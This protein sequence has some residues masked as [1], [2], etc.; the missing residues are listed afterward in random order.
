MNEHAGVR[1]FEMVFQIIIAVIAAVITIAYI[2]NDFQWV[3][4]ILGLLIGGISLFRLIQ[5]T[6]F[7]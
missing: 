7:E 4:A 6:R 3:Y 1:K 2:L 5:I